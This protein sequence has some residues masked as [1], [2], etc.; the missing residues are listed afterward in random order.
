MFAI[1]AKIFLAILAVG[2]V[3]G[4]ITS[5]AKGLRYPY[6]KRITY[7]EFIK[8][9]PADGWY[10]VTGGYLDISNAILPSKQ[11]KGYLVPFRADGEP[12]SG[13]VNALV[14]VEDDPLVQEIDRYNNAANKDTTVWGMSHDAQTGPVPTST[15]IE[16]DISGMIRESGYHEEESDSSDTPSDRATATA[17]ALTIYKNK[18]PSILLGIGEIIAGV[19]L[20]GVSLATFGIHLDFRGLREGRNAGRAATPPSPSYGQP[21]YAPAPPAYQPYGQ[22]PAPS[23]PPV[24]ASPATPYPPPSPSTSQYQPPP[25]ASYQPYGQP[26]PAAVAEPPSAPE[27]D[28]ETRDKTKQQAE[29]DKLRDLKPFDP[30]ADQ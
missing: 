27:P 20:C 14:Y 3:L 4:G 18:H 7:A 17:N 9:P 5:V 29:I 6:P 19:L 28:R 15:V 22:Q 16:T 23:A 1:R 11:A 13:R 21:T 25:A 30:F 26:P 10:D 2:M 8:N 12:Q 24:Q